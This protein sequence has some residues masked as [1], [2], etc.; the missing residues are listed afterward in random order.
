MNG[1]CCGVGWSGAKPEIHL[2]SGMRFQA[3]AR[4]MC[5]EGEAIL[6]GLP[7][8]DALQQLPRHIYWEGE[9]SLIA[10]CRLTPGPQSVER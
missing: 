1:V 2:P 4:L 6:A 7:S 10:I 3:L 5:W 8:A 9:F